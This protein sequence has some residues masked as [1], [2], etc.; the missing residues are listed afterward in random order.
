MTRKGTAGAE[1]MNNKKRRDVVRPIVKR[2]VCNVYSS[3]QQPNLH[4]C[5][6]MQWS[7]FCN[8]VNGWLCNTMAIQHVHILE[9]YSC[10]LLFS[11]VQ[12]I[13]DITSSNKTY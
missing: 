8:S 11:F 9:D 2:K 1:P 7:Y 6:Q 5:T 4:N 10:H 12:K 13:E 3:S